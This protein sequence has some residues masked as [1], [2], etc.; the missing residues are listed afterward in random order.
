MLRE[1]G[2]EIE[3]TMEF[4]NIETVKRAVE[5]ENGVSIVPQTSV[6]DEARNGSL[7]PVEVESFD[8]WRPLGVLYRR[9]RAISPAQKQFVTL[10]KEPRWLEEKGNGRSPG[11]DDCLSLARSRVALGNALVRAVGLPLHDHFARRSAASQT[12][13]FPNATWERGG[14]GDARTERHCQAA[15]DPAS[16][17]ILP[18]MKKLLILAALA[19]AAPILAA[20]ALLGA[21]GWIRHAACREGF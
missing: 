10:L 6:A 9:H 15:G 12:N 16:S 8:M 18:C 11:R 17:A 14:R 2:V 13:S 4:D 1:Q 20:A 3:H 5:I 19:A 7:V 21:S